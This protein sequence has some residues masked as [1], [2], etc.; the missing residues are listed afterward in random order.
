MDRLVIELAVLVLAGVPRH[1]GDLEGADALHTPLMSGTNAIH[2]IV[3]RRGAADRRHR[4]ACCH[5]CR[6]RRDDPRRDNVVGGF[7]VTDRML[8]MFKKRE[9]PRRRDERRRERAHGARMRSHGRPEPTTLDPAYLVTIVCFLSRCASPKPRDRAARQLD[10]RGRDGDRD[11]RRRCCTPASSS[12]G[13]SSSGARSAP[14][15]GCR[16]AQGEDDR[17]AADGGAVQRRR[18][19]R[20]RT[21]LAR[22]VPPARAGARA[23]PRRRRLSIVSRR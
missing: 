11:R 18:R 20:G 8:E 16:R 7:V 15:S 19:R 5:R 9:P 10:R 13:G 4:P 17:D 1:R 12:A 21:G 6:V 14:P 3:D 22:R 2:G 23:P